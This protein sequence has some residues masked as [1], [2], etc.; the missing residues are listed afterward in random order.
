MGRTKRTRKRNKQLKY[1]NLDVD[2]AII[3]MKKYLKRLGWTPVIDLRL[4][5][6]KNTGRG[7]FSKKRVNEN[8]M[9]IEIPFNFMISY[10][11]IMESQ[12]KDIFLKKS[13]E[14]KEMKMQ[15]LLAVFLL[16]ERHRGRFSDW[17]W[18]IDT[19]PVELPCLAWLS[20][21]KEVDLLPVNLRVA[22]EQRRWSF[23]ES[24][25]RVRR[26]IDASW[27]CFCCKKTADCVFTMNSFRWGYVMVN[28]RAVYVDPD[29][30]RHLSLISDIIVSLSDA[31]SMALC[32]YLDMFNHSDTVRTSASLEGEGSDYTFK[33]L[34]HVGYGKN[35]QI[36]IS[37]GG[38]D[39]LKLLC[40]YGFFIK[41]NCC[42]SV[43]FS[44]E[45]VLSWT[46]LRTGE[47]QYKFIKKHNLLDKLSISLEEPSFNLKAVLYV[48]L[49]EKNPNSWNSTI[50][51]DSY[52][53]NIWFQI[54]SFL[55]MLLIEAKNKLQTCLV[56]LEIEPCDYSLYFTNVLEYMRNR[57]NF[58]EDVKLKYLERTSH[59]K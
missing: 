18:Y 47:L 4:R 8:D 42:D 37:Y 17:E 22:I 21:R 1:S 5:E 35:E 41:N 45:E 14:L 55:I 20:E 2:A 24:W 6:F 19:L 15:D 11:T 23:E 27:T 29:I 25:E 9:L 53:R 52:P 30:V 36:F 16:L 39:N 57:L 54:Y 50:F 3:Q 13:L 34:T 32:P 26:S 56:K 31:P 10:T 49:D 40:E 48:I 43:D 33:L 44:F 38:H 59:D 51:T 12:I 46:K 28:T 58:I 7:V